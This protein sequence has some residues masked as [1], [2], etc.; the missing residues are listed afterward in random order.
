MM[1]N[2]YVNNQ[3]QINV[4]KTMVMIITNDKEVLNKSINVN[5]NKIEN[6][7]KIKILGTTINSKLNWDDHIIN[8]SG[9]LIGQLK[10]RL[11]SLKSIAKT[12]SQNF[13]K[14]LA[15]SLIISKLNYNIEVWGNTSRNNRN[16]I[17]QI[18]Y[19][20]ARTVLGNQAIGKT[21]IWI[22]NT[23]KWFNME[24]NYLNTTQNSIY[25]II[26][27]Q[28]EHYFKNE[29]TKNRT[30]R[31][32][33]QNKVGHHDQAIGRTTQSQKSF[34][35]T[36]VNIYNKLPQNL[37]LIRNPVI[38]KKWLKKYNFNNKIK[39]REQNDNIL[40]NEVQIINDQ[41]IQDCYQDD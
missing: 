39:L 12:I 5:G 22:M 15:N 9:S 21:K 8:G 33:T 23:M 11:N 35:Y 10:Q 24:Q 7:S 34:L 30:I 32:F 16:K 20:A 38:F 19:A 27:S 3:L 31:Y 37:T 18:L 13:A 1:N 17:D 29:L 40:I 25:K 26:N 28:N 36:A 14:Q 4:V 6:K 41:N 2:Y